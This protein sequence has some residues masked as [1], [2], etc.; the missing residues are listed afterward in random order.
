[1]P[2]GR[3]AARARQVSGNILFCEGVAANR[4]TLRAKL[5]G[6]G[7]RVT[8]VADPACLPVEAARHRP[9]IVL[10]DLDGGA[11]DALA[12]LREIRDAAG[13]RGPDIV[14]LTAAGGSDI[15]LAALEAGALT[16]LQKPVD[17]GLL[18]AVLRRAMRERNALRPA[19]DGSLSEV[20]ELREA[21]VVADLTPPR[22]CLVAE[23]SAQASAWRARL[24]GL[25]G[26]A[27][28]SPVT[29]ATLMRAAPAAPAADVFLIS[30]TAGDPRRSLW[31]LSE[32]RSRAASR[33]SRICVH[34]P[35]VA[36]QAAD[37]LTIAYDLG[38]DD[39]LTGHACDLE[40]AARLTRQTAR[41]RFVQAV[42]RQLEAGLRLATRDPLTGAYNRRYAQARIS[43]LLQHSA[44]AGAGFS[45]LALDLDRFKHVND[46]HG[47]DGG[48][49]VLREVCR[50]IGGELRAT[51]VLVRS[52]GEEFWAILPETRA[53]E[54]AEIAH[55]IAQAV[56]TDPVILPARKGMV[57]VTISIGIA[58]GSA[59][60]GDTLPEAV[61]AKADAALY[62]AKADGR[63]T[64]IR[65]GVAA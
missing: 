50:R 32:I 27:H 51:D 24:Q 43:K 37:T 10:C 40:V 23:E 45:I 18:M 21:E 19:M 56:R 17:V 36:G 53:A 9:E 13:E 29:P 42:E 3:R 55:R 4:I 33:D 57:R 62:R 11:G 1:M 28:L 58:E 26:R 41:R 5:S 64:V 8:G 48:D 14:C 30:A 49:A 39:V 54:A 6:A 34:V 12:A 47:H 20:S 44:G 7:Y 38:A 61:I 25:F 65:A 22:I 52:G 16:L 15:R 2:A 35:K 63:D 31:L 46:T 59:G 60:R